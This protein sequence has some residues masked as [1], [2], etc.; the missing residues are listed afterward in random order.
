M[1]RKHS[2]HRSGGRSQPQGQSGNQ[3][4]AGRY[5]RHRNRHPGRPQ[6]RPHDRPPQGPPVD[7][8]APPKEVAGIVDILPKG[9]GFL[10]QIEN[11]LLQSDDDSFLS[12]QVI[13]QFG[14][15]Q[16]MHVRGVAKPARGKSMEVS[17][18]TEINFLPAAEYKPHVPFDRQISIDPTDRLILTPAESR[19]PNARCDCSN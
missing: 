9:S 10:R 6:D 19:M 1:N 8:N 2:Q 14:L 13:R 15:T 7:S 3:H 5:R 17:D 4:P 16:G 18:I 11:D 12:P